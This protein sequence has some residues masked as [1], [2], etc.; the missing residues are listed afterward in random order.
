[1]EKTKP[2]TNPVIEID[3]GTTESPSTTQSCLLTTKSKT[4]KLPKQNSI[5]LLQGI[6]M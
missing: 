1:M 2:V 6:T 4:K 3:Q 5:M